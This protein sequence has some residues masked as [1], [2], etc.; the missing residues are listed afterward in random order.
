MLRI[1]QGHQSLVQCS[2]FSPCKRM[3]A[4]GSW[5]HTVRVWPLNR[6]VG[7]W[8]WSETP[9]HATYIMGPVVQTLT[10][11]NIGTINMYFI[12]LQIA[13]AE[14]SNSSILSHLLKWLSWLCHCWNDRVTYFSSNLFIISS[15]ISLWNTCHIP[16]SDSNFWK[17]QNFLSLVIEK[18]HICVEN[19]QLVVVSHIYV[20]CV[21]KAFT[22]RNLLHTAVMYMH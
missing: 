14:C 2:A 4:T 16:Y 11:N 6:S 17:V 8:C 15:Y 9:L 10:P 19:I 22:F 1:F 3:L 21:F 18:H 13:A 7:T 5:D 12:S 20:F